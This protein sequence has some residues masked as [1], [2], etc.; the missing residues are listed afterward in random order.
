MIACPHVCKMGSRLTRVPQSSSATKAYVC[1]LVRKARRQRKPHT[2]LR[3]SVGT[4]VT[5]SG[6]PQVMRQVRY[7]M[8][9]LYPVVKGHSCN[10][11]ACSAQTRAHAKH[12]CHLV[13][14]IN[15]TVD[16]IVK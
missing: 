16:C 2:R 11:A 4:L 3:A 5:D 15:S 8:H 12:A 7:G 10:Q 13:L 6:V 9:V 14:R 1:D